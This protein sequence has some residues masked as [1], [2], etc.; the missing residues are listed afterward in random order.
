MSYIVSVGAFEG[1]FDLLLQLI[2][3]REMDIYDV[4]LGDII[5]D[6]LTVLR[7]METLDLEATTEFLMVAATLVELKAARLLPATDEPELDQVALEARDLLYARLLD[8]QV[9]IAA[10]RFVAGRLDEQSGYLARSVALEERFIG[11]APPVHV[12]LSPPELATLMARLLEQADERTH[13]VDISHLQPIRL[14]VRQAAELITDELRRAGGRASFRE[15]TAGYRHREEVVV[16]FLAVLEL[17]K[18]EQ[19]EVEQPATCGEL[20]IEFT[21]TFGAEALPDLLA[22][23]ESSR[24]EGAR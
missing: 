6:Y 20:I 17:F 14:T 9:F 3:H 22:A 19:I 24:V 2:A 13:P 10:A 5:D 7:T 18:S 23:P 16:A 4:P 12:P 11:C 8:Y 1:P 21:G 15:L